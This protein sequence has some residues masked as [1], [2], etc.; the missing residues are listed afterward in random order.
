MEYLDEETAARAVELMNNKSRYVR[1][2]HS[3]KCPL[4]GAWGE[5][6]NKTTKTVDN[7]V[8]R[9]FKCPDCGLQYTVTEDIANLKMVK[10]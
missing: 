10:F 4:C 1:A 5:R 6:A 7:V 8:Y 2:M 3:G 9:Y